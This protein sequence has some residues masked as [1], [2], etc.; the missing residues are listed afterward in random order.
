MQYDRIDIPDRD[1]PRAAAPEFQHL[2]DIYAS[3]TNKTASVWRMFAATDLTWRP[4]PRSSTVEE[5]MRHQLLSERR[6]FGEFLG[7]REPPASE[8]LPQRAAVD[9]FVE[10]LVQLAAPRLAWIA[11]QEKSAWLAR[12]PFFDVERER[13]WIFWRRVLH[14][15]H[16]RTQLTAY[17][18]LL[19]KIVPPTYGP[20]ADVSWS[21]ADPTLTV[22]A[23]GRAQ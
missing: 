4:H 20:T 15:A 8:V 5:I 16:H 19:N 9:T 13:I 21:G 6:F 11:A 1:V 18:R 2:V 23:A 17:L 22:E 7:S 12:V 3:E 10:R 14:S